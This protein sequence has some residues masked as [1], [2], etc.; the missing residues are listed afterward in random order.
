[1]DGVKIINSDQIGLSPYNKM[2]E[3]HASQN[4]LNHDTQDDSGGTR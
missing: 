2:E 4:Q 1:M 3:E